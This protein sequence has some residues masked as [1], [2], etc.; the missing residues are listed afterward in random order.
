MVGQLAIAA[1][2]VHRFD[3]NAGQRVVRAA[4]AAGVL[5][6]RCA[7]GALLCVVAQHGSLRNAVGNNGAGGD[8]AVAV[9]YLDP[10]IVRHAD[11]LGVLIGHPDH[12][13]TARDGEHVQVVKVL[14][15][16][17]PLI[18][19]GQVTQGD[20]GLAPVIGQFRARR[21]FAVHVDVV[22]RW[23]E[24]RQR[25]AVVHEPVVVD[26]VLHTAGQ[27]VPGLV[28]LDVDGKG[29]VAALIALIGGPLRGGDDL[30]RAFLDVVPRDAYVFIG[31]A[32]RGEILAGARG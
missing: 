3:G 29:G 12:L 1:S 19:R 25:F 32:Q 21:E 27:R 2:D 13:A 7:H 10:V 4:A 30:L 11:F 14:R 23:A 18:V 9:I 17:G 24:D 28:E 26:V 31:S 20:L 5:V 8:D 16:D 22:E 6:D 15:M